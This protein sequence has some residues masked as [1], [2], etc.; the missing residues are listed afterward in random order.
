MKI[1]CVGGGPAGLYLGIL[2]KRADPN[3]H[4]VVYERKPRGRLDGWGV[5]F[6][7]DLL[8]DLHNTDPETAQRVRQSAIGW[9]GQRIA[10]DGEGAV[11]EGSGYGIARSRLL[12][13]LT[14]RALEV[15]VEIHFEHA[16]TTADE[17]ADADV[18]VASDGVNSTIRGKDNARF[19]SN[20]V[21]GRNKYAWLATDKHLDK[22]TFAFARTPAG[23]IW[24][25]GYAFGD[26]MSTCIIETTPETWQGLG[27]DTLS[28]PDSLSLLENAFGEQLGGGRLFGLGD[29][30]APL[31]WL[32]YRTLTN[33]RWSEGNTVLVGDAAH[34]THFSI[35]SGTR[36]ALQDAI[37]LADALQHAGSPQSAFAVYEKRRRATILTDQSN[38]RHSR[39]WFEHIERYGDLPMPVFFG[40]L[41]A[42]RD[43]LLP[44][45]P[46]ALYY[47]FYATA[48]RIPALRTAKRRVGPAARK[49]YSK[50]ARPPHRQI[51]QVGSSR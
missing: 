24:S 16:V 19:G 29:H 6:W 12:T 46:P 35:G 2:M 13:I 20:I 49:L 23:L 3:N 38:A 25:H 9:Q 32:N 10:L 47:R 17:V 34:T 40:L 37:G 41:R 14:E 21:V 30:S 1:V 7:D 18:V 27:L 44:H 39:L 28:G 11:Y 51:D 31:Q 48:E 4:V 42:R 33:E 36:L 22:F 26:G 8:T 50:L 5:G 43:P 15:G 45:V